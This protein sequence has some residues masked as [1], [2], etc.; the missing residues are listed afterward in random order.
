MTGL[1][2]FITVLL[3][4]TAF[5]LFFWSTPVEATIH[6]FLDEHF[7]QDQQNE[8]LRWPHMTD[9]RNGRGWHWNPRPPY[10][11]AEPTYTDYCWG[12]QELIYNR[13]VI[14]DAETPQALWCAY[15]NRNNAQQPRWPDENDYMPDQNAWVWWGPVDLTDAVS[16]H[17]SF[18]VLV[19]IDNFNNDSLSVVVTDDLDIITSDN[20]F[21]HANAPVGITISHRLNEDWVQRGF[22]VDSLFV[23][24]EQTSMLEH[25]DVW[26]AFVWHSDGNAVA[27][28][29]KGPFIDDVLFS[30]DDGLFDIIADD[31]F[32]GYEIEGQEDIHWTMD[33]PMNGEDVIFRQDYYVSGDGETPEFDIR[34]LHNEELMYSTTVVCNGASDSSFTVNADT[35]WTATP[36]EHTFRW[37]LDAP[38]DEN[39]VV[40]ESDETNNSAELVFEVEYNPA[41]SFE[42]AP[43]DHVISFNGVAPMVIDWF[44]GDSLNDYEFD[45]TLYWTTDTTGLASDPVLVESYEFIGRAFDQPAGEGSFSW[46]AD[47]YLA[48]VPEDTF[49]VAGLATDGYPGNFSISA[50]SCYDSRGIGG[51]DA[52][53]IPTEMKLN[54]AYPNPFNSMVKIGYDIVSAGRAQI[55]VFDMSGRIVHNLDCGEQLPGHHG[56]VWQPEDIPAGVYLIRLA[57]G[58]KMDY[59][60]TVYM[61]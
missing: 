61:P 11:G 58:G 45:I 13:F 23:D 3:L 22:W 55:A 10:R 8:N 56:V 28:G 5:S 7:N 21:F 34:L 19:D 41:P 24:G 27:E 29:D 57:S 59:M 6:T 2:R 12:L 46:A 16:A 51:E 39:G 47:D 49:F 52:I 50:V 20:D 44:I 36:G 25:E 60:K 14:V 53:D 32:M 17:V 26:L 4:G 48:V 1:K 30:W 43:N 42:L 38:L 18:W 40:E 15:T 35:I 37:E 9:L 54:S 31:A 33:P